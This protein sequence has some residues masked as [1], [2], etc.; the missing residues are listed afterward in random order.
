MIVYYTK[1]SYYFTSHKYDIIAFLFLSFSQKRQTFLALVSTN[2]PNAYT[3]LKHTICVYVYCF[4]TVFS[5]THTYTYTVCVWERQRECSVATRWP[6][7]SIFIS[8]SAK[9]SI[10]YYALQSF[11]SQLFFLFFLTFK[12]IF[13]NVCWSIFVGCPLHNCAFLRG[14][15]EIWKG[16]R[17]GE[18]TGHNTIFFFGEVVL[19][20]FPFWCAFY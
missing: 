6:T 18:L 12:T 19:E 2:Q 16:D 13:L 1:V 20:I 11:P 8:R 9:F 14:G 17:L 15:M 5:P 4:A 7:C 3:Y 10:V